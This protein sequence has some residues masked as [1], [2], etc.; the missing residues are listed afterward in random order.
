MA[1]GSGPATALGPMERNA[2]YRELVG[3]C[4]TAADIR[5]SVVSVVMARDG[6]LTSNGS[7]GTMAFRVAAWDD[8]QLQAV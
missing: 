1:D 2:T 8:D 3:D 5:V 7:G 4:A 6:S